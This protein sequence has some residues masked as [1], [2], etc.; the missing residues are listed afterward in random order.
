M[1]LKITRIILACLLA[2]LMLAGVVALAEEEV[3]PPKLSM[4]EKQYLVKGKDLTLTIDPYENVD[5]FEI[6]VYETVNG[7]TLY[8]NKSVE[9]GQLKIGK[10]VFSNEGFYVV[11]LTA[12]GNGSADY[13]K[14]YASIFPIVF[15]S[16]PDANGINF[17]YNSSI[18]LGENL[19]VGVYAPGAVGGR[20]ATNR[21]VWDFDGEYGIFQFYPEET[22]N[23]TTYA[24]VNYPDRVVRTQ[25]YPY[26]VSS[27]GEIQYSVDLPDT[28]TAGEPITIDL[29]VATVSGSPRNVYYSVDVM[30]EDTNGEEHRVFRAYYQ[31]ALDPNDG[32][33]TPLIGDGQTVVIPASTF[34]EGKQY[35]LYVSVTA[36]PCGM[37]TARK[38]YRLL[39][40]SDPRVSVSADGMLNGAITVAVGQ[41]FTL[42]V[43]APGAKAI[44]F[45][46][47]YEY[48]YISF[49]RGEWEEWSRTGS[50]DLEDCEF[51]D[52]NDRMVYV[53]AC[54][55]D[56]DINWDTAKNFTWV[57]SNV[58]TVH[59]TPSQQ[60]PALSIS[61]E[62][63]VDRGDYLV[64]TV[65]DPGKG[66]GVGAGIGDTDIWMEMNENNQI[67]LPTLSLEPGRYSLNV[68]SF[69]DGYQGS[70]AFSTF[71]VKEVEMPENPVLY[72]ARTDVTIH[73]FGNY[74][75][76]ADGAAYFLMYDQ[77]DGDRDVDRYDA[78]ENGVAVFD[79]EFFYG[80]NHTVYAVAY[81]AADEVIGSTNFVQVSVVAQGIGPD[82]DIQ[83]PM[84]AVAGQPLEFT[85]SNLDEADWHWWINVRD[86]TT[87]EDLAEFSRNGVG[88][89]EDGKFVVE[90]GII[91]NHVYNIDCWFNF[92]GKEGV[93]AN[94]RVTA[95]GAITED[96]KLTING[97]DKEATFLTGEDQTI[98]VTAAGMKNVRMFDGNNWQWIDT[99]IDEENGTA[100]FGYS[101]GSG[102]HVIM[103]QVLYDEVG[104]DFD[105]NWDALNW[106]ETSNIITVH[107]QS[108][109]QLEEPSLTLAKDSVVQGELLEVTIGTVEKAETY[110]IGIYA[111]ENGEQFFYTGILAP[112]DGSDTITMSLPTA[113]LEPGMY[114]VH[115]GVGAIGMD[116]NDIGKFFNVTAPQGDQPVVQLSAN[117]GYTA[118]NFFVNVYA[119]GADHCG[120][121]MD[122]DC[123]D[124]PNNTRTGDNGWVFSPEFRDGE[125]SVYVIV[126]YPDKDP[127]QSETFTVIGH[128]KEQSVSIHGVDSIVSAGKDLTFTVEGLEIA[129]T[130]QAN[131]WWDLRIADRNSGEDYHYTPMNTV[132]TVNSFTIPGAFLV[133]GDTYDIDVNVHAYGYTDANDH[134]SFVALNDSTG[135]VTLTANGASE[136]LAAQTNETIVFDVATPAKTTVIRLY[137]NDGWDYRFIDDD[138]PFMDSY[139]NSGVYSVVAQISTTP[140]DRDTFDWN[141][142]SLEWTDTSNAV[143]INV[144][145]IGSVEVGKITLGSDTV[146]RGEMVRVQFTA[147]KHAQ[148]YHVRLRDL[149]YGEYYFTSV[150]EAGEVL[151]PTASVNPGEYEIEVW[152]FGEKGYESNGV[153]AGVS[154]TEAK[155]SEKV[156]LIFDRTEGLMNEAVVASAYYP[157]AARFEITYG[158]PWQDPIYANNGGGVDFEVRLISGDVPFTI[159]A[160]DEAGNAMGKSETVTLKGINYGQQNIVS[161]MPSVVDPTKEITFTVTGLNN[162]N[163]GW[164]IDLLRQEGDEQVTVAHWDW[165][166]GANMEMTTFTIAANT[167]KAG[168]TYHFAV[169]ADAIGYEHFGIWQ[170]LYLISDTPSGTVTLTVDGSATEAVTLANIDTHFHIEAPGATMVRVICSKDNWSR[171]WTPD[172]NGVV[173]V[174]DGL[175]GGTYLA[176]AMAAYNDLS[177][178][179]EPIWS[180]SSNTVSLT[181][182]VKGVLVP[183][184]LDVPAT[185]K[186]G[187]PLTLTLQPVENAAYYHL[188]IFGQNDEQIVFQSFDH[189][190]QVPMTVN[191]ITADVEPGEYYV[192]ASYGA[193]GYDWVGTR[194]YPITVEPGD[195]TLTLTVERTEIYAGEPMQFGVFA[196]NATRIRVDI[197]RNVDDWH[198]TKEVDGSVL[199]DSVGDTWTAGTYELTARYWVGDQEANQTVSRIVTVAIKGQLKAPTTDLKKLYYSDAPLTVT[200]GEVE[201]AKWYKIM[202]AEESGEWVVNYDFDKPGTYTITPNMYQENKSLVPN[203]IYHIEVSVWCEGYE[204]GLSENTRFAY[205]PSD[206]GVLTLPAKL[207]QISEGA[208][209]GISAHVVVASDSLTVIEKD[210]F[211]NNGILVIVAPETAQIDDQ[212]TMWVRLTPAEYQA[213]KA[214]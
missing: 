198:E 108:N 74:S 1:N 3:I 185:V 43:D 120:L 113:N 51:G 149:G 83:A 143:T 194:Q 211:A 24:A 28:I 123:I 162:A 45:Y 109:G 5:H 189:E 212:A 95:I 19:A 106:S 122:G 65:N 6:A 10:E 4:G 68:D 86:D 183:A 114:R 169:N 139:G 53:E 94:A 46:N 103:A 9:A 115:V 12:V 124:D 116:G 75:A 140:V 182:N 129:Q 18:G 195:A 93:W 135:S 41:H 55:D 35:R 155:E 117:E 133:A 26:T 78:D 118:Q 38:L 209:T 168:E 88:P 8:Q 163:Q 64:V 66:I 206:V 77:N 173:D 102:D 187:E 90:N 142:E 37:W 16:E 72:A 190:E 96:I 161:T 84:Y 69:A 7:L 196:P 97:E 146:S 47:G 101:F 151:I 160:V 192:H 92:F 58:I 177:G 166:D 200:F 105:G 17:V 156:L 181:V 130:I 203:S 60:L 50:F 136:T 174:H 127:W 170:D 33:E 144:T 29:P 132:G 128:G 175:N 76:Y 197:E 111:E 126:E 137:H 121:F 85:V 184:E 52:C 164:G 25:E 154:V 22:G 172:A 30:H 176:T 152:Y 98:T 119:P 57:T 204:S 59:L 178:G 2:V 13:E 44:R 148:E 32:P 87:G 158:D 11:T 157:E 201:N 81:N 188:R 193:D 180:K 27:S 34:E 134:V 214:Q 21:D 42:H 107:V 167:M 80:G 205:I 208:F 202:I 71:V 199:R 186:Q 145:S 147:G 63:T 89:N 179:A 171:D 70:S 165:Q 159:Q 49:Y 191:L 73:D 48:D 67:L 150:Q 31:K 82:P 15:A 112:E 56:G 110:N 213:I 153:R 14:R 79:Y 20:I 131:R 141:W 99:M 36:P 62:G 104:D 23:G 207:T 100:T 125:H 54:F 40:V 91:E 61:H 39:T 138:N 210:A